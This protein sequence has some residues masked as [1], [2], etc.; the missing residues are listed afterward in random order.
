M[1]SINLFIAL[2]LLC[3]PMTAQKLK[4]PDTKKVDQV[5]TYFGTKVS[6]PYR[7]LEDDRAAEVEKW[8]TEENSVTFGYLDKIPFRKQVKARLEEFVNYPRYSNP[9]KR[10]EYYYFY[11]NDGL[12]NQSVLYRQK[13]LNGEVELFLDPNLLS[14]DGTVALHG[15]NFSRDNK[16]AAYEISRSGSDWQEIRV[17]ETATRKI[18]PDSIAWNKFSGASWFGN[19][20]FYSRYD[21]PKNTDKAYSEKN[22][23]HKV[24]YHKLG[25]PQIQDELAFQDS[26]ELLFFS[27][28]ATDDERFLFL[29]KSGKAKGNALWFKDVKAGDKDFRPL[30]ES[31]DYEFGVID[32][33]DDKIFIQSNFE[34]ANSNII[35]IDS[36]SPERKNWKTIIPEKEYPLSFSSIV[37][38]KIIVGYAKDVKIIVNVFDLAG[39]FENEIPL[40]TAGTASGFGGMRSDKETFYTFTS[41]TYP[42]TVYRYEIPEKKTTLF[43]KSELK[44]NPDEFE[45]KQVFYP[46]KDGTKIPMYIVYKKGLKLDG[47]NPTLLYA[48]GGFNV[49]L[50][51]AFSALRLGWLEQGGI[52]AQANL[53]GGN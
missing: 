25:T 36:K 31:M 30:M 10:G 37:G 5:D 47:N 28:N 29:Y 49:S 21:E 32:N 9:F 40:P 1:K 14:S 2:S 20:F 12:Q 38:D 13:G 17:M 11:K 23:F 19:G 3:I 15:I 44:F 18:L 53:R 4:Y 34:A 8:V 52:Y 33:A 39:N 42:S 6:D 51:P 16:Y 45:T 7:W 35:M 26:S 41:F 24:Y 27:V 48:Y 50:N 22:T 43:R 46:S